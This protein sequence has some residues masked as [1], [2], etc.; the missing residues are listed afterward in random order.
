M[1]V[2]QR[3]V[4]IELVQFSESVSQFSS[5]QFSTV[6]RPIGSWGRGGGGMRDDSAE[7]LLQSQGG[8]CEQFWHGQGCPLMD[9]VH[10][11]FPLSTMAPPTLHDAL[12]DGFREAVVA[13]D[14]PEPCMFP[15]F[16]R[17]QKR[18]L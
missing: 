5:V 6:L 9:V 10:P 3:V 7:A 14:I 18:F 1:G 17:C 16:D 4:M 12:K 13:C 15:S 11:A 2:K 8:P